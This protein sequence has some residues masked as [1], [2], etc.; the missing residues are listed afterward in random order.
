MQKY[1]H[2]FLCSAN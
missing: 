2:L 1:R